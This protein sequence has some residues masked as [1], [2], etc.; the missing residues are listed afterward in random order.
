MLAGSGLLMLQLWYDL[1]WQL[2]TCQQLEKELA[3]HVV[4]DGCNRFLYNLE[5]YILPTEERCIA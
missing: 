5:N 2:H 1:L 3:S 4:T